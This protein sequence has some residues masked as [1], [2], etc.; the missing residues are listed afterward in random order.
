MPEINR[1]YTERINGCLLARSP[2]S[3][4]DQQSDARS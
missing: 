2:S 1:S 3:L 4:F